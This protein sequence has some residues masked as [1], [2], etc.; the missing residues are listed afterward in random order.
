MAMIRL[1]FT[2]RV[3]GQKGLRAA[4]RRRWQQ[5]PHLSV[6]LIYLRDIIGYLAQQRI[7]FYRLADALAPYLTHG[8]H[9]EFERQIEECA[10]EL[11]AVGAL[12]QEAGVRL[13][14]HLGAHVGLAAED[15]VL[16]ARAAAEIVAQATLLDGLGM[17]AESVLV[18]H[19]G[20]GSAEGAAA[21]QRFAERYRLLPEHARRRVAL[22][23]DDQ[24]WSLEALLP[25]HQVC[26][27]PLVMDVLHHHLNAGRLSPGAALGLA[28]GTWPAGVRPKVHFSSPR[29]EA[30]LGPRGGGVAVLP[31]RPGQHAD[32][33]NPFEFAHFLALARGLPPFD[34]M[35]EAKAGDLALL[36]LREDLRGYGLAPEKDVW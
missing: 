8:A 36:R 21:L 6:S 2:V 10:G 19:V 32:F 11:A 5:Q 26:G 16:A 3:L 15:S 9:A 27:V 4:D 31:P 24:G 33:I 20:G 34:V 1:G 30:H 14:M 7:G 17:S 35:L 23:H 18:L 28:L 22:E 29:T 25:L 12:A 13:T